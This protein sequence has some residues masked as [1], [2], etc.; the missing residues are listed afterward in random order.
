MEED[1]K[2]AIKINFKSMITTLKIPEN[3]DAMP[4]KVEDTVE[5]ILEIE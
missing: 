5:F 3:Y 1:T 2:E 4:A